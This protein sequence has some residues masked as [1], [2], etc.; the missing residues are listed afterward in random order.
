MDS[1]VES[2]LIEDPDFSDLDVLTEQIE[3]GTLQF[4]EDVEDFLSKES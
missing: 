1:I 4:I 3:T 2:V